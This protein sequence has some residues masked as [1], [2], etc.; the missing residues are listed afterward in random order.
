M[1][2][3]HSFMKLEHSFTKFRTQFYEE[4]FGKLCITKLQSPMYV[5]VLFRVK[6]VYEYE[7]EGLQSLQS[8]STS[9]KTETNSPVL[10]PNCDL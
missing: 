9:Y 7:Y 1:K 5:P 6:F 3:E 4:N 2:L 10:V 8:F